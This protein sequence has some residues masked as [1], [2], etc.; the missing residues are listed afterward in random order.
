MAPTPPN[1]RSASCSASCGEDDGKTNL[2]ELNANPEWA[3]IGKAVLV[4]APIL[5][6]NCDQV[7]QHGAGIIDLSH[8]QKGEAR[9]DAIARP[10][11]MI[12]ANGIGGVSTRH[13]QAGDERT[14]VGAVLMHFQNDSR[15]ISFSP[16]VGRGIRN[17]ESF[18]PLP[19]ACDESL[20]YRVTSFAEARACLGTGSHDGVGEPDHERTLRYWQLAEQGYVA[21]NGFAVFPG[22][23]PVPGKI[24]PSVGSSHVS[25]TRS[26]K[27]A[28]AQ[29][30]ECRVVLPSRQIVRGASIVVF[31]AIAEMWCQQC[32][33]RHIVASETIRDENYVST[34]VRHHFDE[35][36][37]AVAFVRDLR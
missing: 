35:Q 4:P 30:A 26:R 10:D 23:S 27:A 9:F 12:A 14:W 29:Q 6:L 17:V 20:A 25:C 32:V 8:S 24:L 28:V 13:A 11:Q 15:Q 33:E 18:P 36:P 34:R 1:P 37:V 22:H 16:D 21:V 5:V 19:P 31:A 3:T 7:G 2:V